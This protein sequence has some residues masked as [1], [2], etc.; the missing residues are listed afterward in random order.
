M[1]EHG[2]LLTG[3]TWVRVISDHE[4]YSDVKGLVSVSVISKNGIWSSCVAFQTH[5]QSE[6][7]LCPLICVHVY[8]SVSVWN[9]PWRLALCVATYPKTPISTRCGTWWTPPT[10]STWCSHSSFSTPSVWLCRW[11]TRVLPGVSWCRHFQNYSCKSCSSYKTLMAHLWGFCSIMG[12]PKI[13]TM[14]WTSSTC[15]S[16]DCSRWRWS[17]NWSPSNP[18]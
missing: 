6:L 3:W 7:W 15:S 16:P 2:W 13:L 5:F 18:G 10:L 4:E 1:E 14:Q 17:L 9:T 11:V 8:Y 12:R